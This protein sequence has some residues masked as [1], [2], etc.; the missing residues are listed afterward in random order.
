MR[1][2]CAIK[3]RVGD[4]SSRTLPLTGSSS[5]DLNPKQEASKRERERARDLANSGEEDL[6]KEKRQRERV[7]GHMMP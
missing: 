2:G 5:L 3:F 4:Y 1:P 7:G 6:A